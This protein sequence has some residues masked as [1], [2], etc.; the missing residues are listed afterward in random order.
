MSPHVTAVHQY[1][2]GHKLQQCLLLLGRS[3][4]TWSP[5]SVQATNVHYTD[6]GFIMTLTMCA[7]LADSLSFFDS[8][9]LKDVIVV[10]VVT[11]TCFKGYALEV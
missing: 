6:A 2:F 3:C 11:V 7:W 8:T 9:V 1:E 5:I 4:V 10:R